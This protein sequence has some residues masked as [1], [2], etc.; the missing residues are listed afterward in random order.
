MTRY[1]EGLW[2]QGLSFHGCLEIHHMIII[3]IRAGTY[4]DN[5]F[6]AKIHL[7]KNLLCMCEPT[8]DDP[9]SSQSITVLTI[10]GN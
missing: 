8:G 5:K 7:T 10:L 9:P 6:V 4:G 1:F 2:T 3:T